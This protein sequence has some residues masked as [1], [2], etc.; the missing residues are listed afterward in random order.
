MGLVQAFIEGVLVVH[1]QTPPLLHEL[2]PVPQLL[3]AAPSAPHAVAERVVQV[4]PVQQPLQ[5]V[6]GPQVQIRVPP[7]QS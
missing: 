3:H 7:L 6:P 4:L 5:P 1:W 2:A